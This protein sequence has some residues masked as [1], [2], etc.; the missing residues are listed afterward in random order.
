MGLPVVSTIHGGIPELV[1]DGVSGFL[2]P[3]RDA[4]A[5]AEKLADLLSH[6]ERWPEMG[7]AGRLFVER[8]FDL[9]RLN[10]KLVLL[11]EDLLRKAHDNPN[12]AASDETEHCAASSN[13][14]SNH[15]VSALK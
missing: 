13:K 5:L 1:E 14:A 10:D 6:P 9:N 8:Y 3:E 12:A 2:A 4:D 11:Y 7:R 15:P